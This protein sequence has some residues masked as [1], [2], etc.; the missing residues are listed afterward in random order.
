MNGKVKVSAA[1]P[2][3]GVLVDVTMQMIAPGELDPDGTLV[4]KK[5]VQSTAIRCTCGFTW[6]PLKKEFA[7]D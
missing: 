5:L 4:V 1:C 6:D 7:D 3:C 2:Q